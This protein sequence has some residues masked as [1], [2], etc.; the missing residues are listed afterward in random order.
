MFVAIGA[1]VQT[2]FA[3]DQAL[4]SPCYAATPPVLRCISGL[5]EGAD[6]IFA[7]AALAEDWVLV[8]A[9]PFLRDEYENDFE[10]PAS[11][12]TYRRLLTQSGS[13]IELDG[14]R[15][16]GGEP[17]DQ[18]G[19]MLLE[20]S[21]MVAAIWDGMPPRGP[22]GTGDVVA[23][24]RAAGRP[25]VVFDA[26]APHLLRLPDNI[27]L[28]ALTEAALVPPQ[29]DGYP[30][31][32]FSDVTRPNPAFA[33]LVSMFER[34]VLLGARP[35]STGSVAAAPAPDDASFRAADS[36]AGAYATEYRAAG[37]I[38]FGVVLPVTLG[39][40]LASFAPVVVRPAG[41]LLQFSA[42]AAVVALSW[43][44]I[45]E[46]PHRRFLA[47]RTLAE[48]LRQNWM[49]QPLGAVATLPGTPGHAAATTDWVAWCA[50]AV[51]RQEAL[52][53]G[54]IDSAV[55]VK[56]VE[57][58]VQH[59]MGQ[60]AYY[61][62]RAETFTRIA[63]RLRRAG[64]ALFLVG[65][66]FIAMRAVAMMIGAGPDSSRLL[67]ESA[68]ILP[69]L[70]PVF[71]GLL[72]FGE[73]SRLSQRYT[74]VA[75]HL[76]RLQRAMPDPVTDPAGCTRARVLQI[77]HAMADAMLAEVADWRVLIRARE[78]SPY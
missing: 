54:A 70:A 16:R 48:L 6:R 36:L 23:A 29:A 37:L 2:A 60:I 46:R 50:R 57:R 59:T 58:I 24:A 64:V 38:R 55:I 51:S 9:L 75:D 39:G 78:I 73:Y 13:V 19:R 15:G 62:R 33:R 7:E 25:V 47:Y 66:G 44:G 1:S 5:A 43:R 77:G 45:W 4:S 17:Y 74:A 52:P 8:A 28:A 32:L 31:Q 61:R 40:F 26:A 20:Q 69:A 53:S 63:E 65:L 3:A 72:G 56:A 68:L 71:L 76:E 12:E 41:L 14:R 49:L 27:G 21:D 30:S 11:R 10:Q 18:L 42:L 34:T 35:R 22:G 67:E